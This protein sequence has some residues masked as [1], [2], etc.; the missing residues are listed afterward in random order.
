[1]KKYVGDILRVI[2]V[3]LFL[4]VTVIDMFV[5]NVNDFIHIAI[6]IFAFILTIIGVVINNKNRKEEVEESGNKD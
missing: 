5:F 4:V 2:G 1:M 6:L 3:L